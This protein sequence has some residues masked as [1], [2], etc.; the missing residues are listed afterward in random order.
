MIE[1]EMSCAGDS[2][3]SLVPWARGLIS[4]GARA[5][6][7]YTT[8]ATQ[9]QHERLV[10][11]LSLPIRYYAASLISI[12]WMFKAF[13]PTRQSVKDSLSTI[14]DGSFVRL[15]T[16]KNMIVDRYRAL[17]HDR[18]SIGGSQFRTDSIRAISPVVAVNSTRTPIPEPPDF[19]PFNNANGIHDAWASYL[20]EPPR[21]L[22]LVGPRSSILSDLQ[23]EVK[24]KG[25]QRSSTLGAL[26][27]NNN[28][29]PSYG[30]ELVS[31]KAFSDD[32]TNRQHCRTVILE[33]SSAT[34][35]MDMFDSPVAIVLVSRNLISD[36]ALEFITQQCDSRGSRID[37][38]KELRWTPPIGI[39]ILAYKV[40][41]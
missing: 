31:S 16:K 7:Y 34:F 11:C 1:L 13:S 22:F 14:P 28:S 37:A 10:I 12:G 23:T 19:G 36:S 40:N 24:V 32:A 15:I 27:P 6:S 26:L 18:I 21:G 41:R 33:G 25:H 39:D 9:L 8:H 2:P 3:F 4:L 29:R 38:T 17:P 20:C 35:I 30:V 5:C